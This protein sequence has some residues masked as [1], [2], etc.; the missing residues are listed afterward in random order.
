M[1]PARY[2][3]AVLVLL[4]GSLPLFAQKITGDITGTV[5]DA[6]GALLTSATVTVANPGTGLQRN[7]QTNSKGAYHFPELPIG[8]YRLE[9]K[10]TGFKTTVRPVEV[11]GAAV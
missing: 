1:R 11:S 9:V 5:T 10:A 6:S 4:L 2:A 3:S 8:S 7:V